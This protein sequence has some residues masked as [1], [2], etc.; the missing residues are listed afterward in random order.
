MNSP[1]AQSDSE[2]VSVPMQSVQIGLDM[3]ADTAHYVGVLEGTIAALCINECKYRALLE[4][5]TG[6]SWEATKID[7]NGSV[8]MDLAVSALVKQTGMSTAKAKTLVFK[9]WNTR[10][11]ETPAVIP[12]AVSTAE[13]VDDANLG[14]SAEVSPAGQPGATMNIPAADA[15]ATGTVTERKREASNRLKAWK[16]R[17]I[18]D[19][20]TISTESS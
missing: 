6:E 11:Q 3:D 19:A 9:R 18:A 20:A 10:N 12:V 13:V 8:L 17:Q 4:L 14:T 1:V 7:V 15:V 2:N 16:E 5:L